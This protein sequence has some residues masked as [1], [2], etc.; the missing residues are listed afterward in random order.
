MSAIQVAGVRRRG[1]SRRSLAMPSA[2]AAGL[3]TAMLAVDAS[4][5]TTTD[6]WAARSTPWRI[7]VEYQRF[8]VGNNEVQRPNDLAGTR[9]NVN[10]FAGSSGNTAWLAVYARPGWFFADDGLRFVVAPFKQSGSGL[11][12]TAILYD[13]A[14]FRAGIPI[15]VSYKF[16]TYRLTYDIPVLESLGS[17]GWDFRVG[18]TIAVRDASVRLSQPAV[19]RNF[20]SWGAIPLLYLGMTR[21][22]GSGWKVLGEVDAFPAPGGGGLF[23]GSLKLAYSVSKTVALTA[24]ARYEFGGATDS[25]FY[26]SL[27]IWSATAGVTMSF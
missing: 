6:L 4:S 25:T 23:D 26:N 22:L 21:T 24:G 27:R 8:D 9:F 14:V 17:D 16:N 1:A 12:R 15:D 13:G 18:G 3:L 10:D 19:S 5:Q 2:L 20:S 11:S 7:D